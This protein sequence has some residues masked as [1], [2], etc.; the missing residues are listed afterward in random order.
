MEV[1]QLL[2]IHLLQLVNITNCSRVQNKNCLTILCLSTLV[3]NMT[4]HI[5]TQCHKNRLP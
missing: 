4:R 2:N 5:H 3:Q 1:H